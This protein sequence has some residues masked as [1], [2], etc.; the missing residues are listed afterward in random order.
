VRNQSR[1]GPSDAL[2]RDRRRAPAR[3]WVGVAALVA[4]TIWLCSSSSLGLT[5]GASYYRV[6]VRLLT[7]SLSYRAAPLCPPL[8][9]KLVKF[10]HEIL[11]CN[12]VHMAA[13][14]L[15]AFVIG[16]GNLVNVVQ[17]TPNSAHYVLRWHNVTLLIWSVL[18]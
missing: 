9:V 12:W 11:C 16:W 4:G 7:A 2:L 3:L 13:V 17:L 8:F 15:P 18:V 5:R 1:K 6:Q 14:Y 10:G